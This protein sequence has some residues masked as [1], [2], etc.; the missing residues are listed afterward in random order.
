MTDTPDINH[1]YPH[2]E[3]S[4]SQQAEYGVPEVII[5]GNE[6]DGIV[7]PLPENGIAAG[8]IISKRRNG[9]YD[10]QDTTATREP[11]Y[12]AMTDSVLGRV[13]IVAT[14]GSRSRSEDKI[15]AAQTNVHG[16]RHRIEANGLPAADADIELLAGIVEDFKRAYNPANRESVANLKAALALFQDKGFRMSKV[17]QASLIDASASMD[18]RLLQ[19][20]RQRAK[21]FKRLKE[22]DEKRVG[23]ERTMRILYGRSLGKT[24]LQNNEDFLTF[25]RHVETKPHL[26]SVQNLGVHMK[27]EDF[28]PQVTR[29]VD[30]FLPA[31]EEAVRISSLVSGDKFHGIKTDDEFLALAVTQLIDLEQ[32]TDKFK[33]VN[34]D[35]H[36]LGTELKQHSFDIQEAVLSDQDIS[37]ARKSAAKYKFLLRHRTLDPNDRPAAWYTPLPKRP[38]YFKK[39]S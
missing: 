30:D 21:N 15:R 29:T 10:E 38:S 25:A 32:H 18:N 1:N 11:H 26:M 27:D 13:A 19:L 5:R 3:L 8:M 9:W 24:A 6:D 23:E 28:W 7:L 12:R 36:E 34:E 37:A 17:A 22:W 14:E 20:Y 35:H 4:A 39:V 2:L 16:L 33:T 31:Y